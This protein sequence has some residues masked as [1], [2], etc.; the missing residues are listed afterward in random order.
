[1][2]IKVYEDKDSTTRWRDDDV[3]WKKKKRNF[4][5]WVTE[6]SHKFYYQRYNFPRHQSPK[7]E[8]ML[9]LSQRMFAET[10]SQRRD[11]EATS[12]YR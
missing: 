7:Q 8:V 1:M 10:I 2:S 11:Q 12:S 9:K 6:T 5:Y 3:S 4:T